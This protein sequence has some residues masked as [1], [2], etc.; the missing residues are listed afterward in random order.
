M[1]CQ[2]NESG[3]GP[4]K[5]VVFMGRKSICVSGT[6]GCGWGLLLLL[7]MCLVSPLLTVFPK[8]HD[9][10]RPTQPLPSAL[11]SPDSANL[12]GTV[13]STLISSLQ[14]VLILSGLC[15]HLLFP[16]G[17]ADILGC[18]A[19]SPRPC[20]FMWPMTMLGAAGV[21]VFSVFPTT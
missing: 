18:K 1:T 14:A 12:Q 7:R 11:S 6:G 5:L 21:C 20:P 17:V 15:P 9:Q 10:E 3:S 16:G 2:G 19:G 4:E 8:S 13:P